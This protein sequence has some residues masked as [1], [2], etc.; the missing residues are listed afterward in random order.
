MMRYKIGVFGSA[1]GEIEHIFK[2]AQ[3]IGEV[4]AS[5]KV[6][7]ITG[8]ASGIPYQ[9]ALAAY[10]KGAEIWGFSPAIDYKSQTLL[11]PNDD[12]SIY[13][14]IFYM[15]KDFQF[16][17]DIQVDRKYRNVISCANC[18]GG[19]IICGRWGTMNE[20]TNLFD[21]GKVI[22]VLTK[23]GGVADELS[24]LNK[25]LHKKSRAKLLFSSSPQELVKMVIEELRKRT[26]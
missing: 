18:D 26:T 3:Q 6:T 22:G 5:Y 9:A 12:N 11:T 25:K 15:P 13:K 23:T 2:K 14:K 21:L 4:L 8:A 24:S 1:E 10:K 19:I 20:F 7:I 16:I 17:K